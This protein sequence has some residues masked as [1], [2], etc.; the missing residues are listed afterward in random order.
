MRTETGVL[1]PVWCY[2]PHQTVSLIN[3]L[4]SSEEDKEEMQV[5]EADSDAF[6]ERDNDF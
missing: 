1:E 5:D 3:L 4:D 2:N 6:D